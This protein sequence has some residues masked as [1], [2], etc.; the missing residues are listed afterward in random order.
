[1]WVVPLIVYLLSRLPDPLPAGAARV[2]ALAGVGAVV[3]VFASCL[4]LIMRNGRGL[5]LAWTPAEFVIGSAYLLVPL[6]AGGFALL[7]L[8]KLR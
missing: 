6:V 1:M 3:A 2:R 8:G 7:R 4:L 5:E